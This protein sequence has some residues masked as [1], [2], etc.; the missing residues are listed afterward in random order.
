MSK[1]RFIRERI[2]DT[3][4]KM[5]IIRLDYS[6]VTNG[7]DLVSLFDKRFPSS[8]KKREERFNRDIN[9]SFRQEDLEVISKTLSLP[10]SVIEKEKTMRYVGMKNVAC[11]AILDISQ[12]YLCMT[13]ECENNYDGLD[14]YVECFK[15]AI[16]VFKDKI[17]YFCP[18]RLGLRKVRVEHKTTL[19]EFDEVFEDFVYIVP[20]Y[21]MNKVKVR[22]TEYIDVIELEDKLRF[23]IRGKIDSTDKPEGYLSSLDIDAY[24]NGEFLASADINSLLTRANL[25]EFEIYKACMKEKYLESIFK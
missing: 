9:I 24:Y 6:G 17:D 4:M 8:F 14:K 15:G 1:D 11:N 22:G 16:T 21:G 25:Q 19:K 23:N 13:I 3:N 2:H 20:D 10:V 12:Y 18:R 5:I 7:G